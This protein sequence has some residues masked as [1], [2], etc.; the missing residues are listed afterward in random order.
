MKTVYIK[1]NTNDAMIIDEIARS[2]GIVFILLDDKDTPIAKY[3]FSSLKLS[4]LDKLQYV[5]NNARIKF[6]TSVKPDTTYEVINSN[7]N[8]N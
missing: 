8:I 6:N 2:R 3:E 5:A 4:F 1:C 7:Y